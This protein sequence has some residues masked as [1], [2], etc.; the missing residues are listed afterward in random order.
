MEFGRP[1]IWGVSVILNTLL[2]TLEI[3]FNTA[4]ASGRVYAIAPWNDGVRKAKAM[5]IKPYNIP[6]VVRDYVKNIFNETKIRSVTPI[7]SKM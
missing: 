4:K 2:I 6:I 3:D 5:A 7:L 1:K